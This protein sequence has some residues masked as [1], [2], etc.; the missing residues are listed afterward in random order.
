MGLHRESPLSALLIKHREDLRALLN[1]CLEYE[2]RLTSAFKGAEHRQREL[3]SFVISTLG[4]IGD[5]DSVTRLR[6]WT[7]HWVYGKYAIRAIETIEQRK[8][9]RVR[10]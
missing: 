7:D 6:A 2:G 8:L 1:Y 10:V 9:L 3:F 5:A 4:E